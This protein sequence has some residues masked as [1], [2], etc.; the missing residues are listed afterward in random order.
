MI[1]FFLTFVFSLNAQE[2]NLDLGQMKKQ[3]K[4]ATV[5]IDDPV[6]GEKKVFDAFLLKDVVSLI[7]KGTSATESSGADDELMFTAID[8]YSPTMP[9]SALETYTGYVA[10]QE[11]GTPGEFHKVTQGKAKLSPGPFY[12]VWKEGRAVK[13]VVPWA[14][15]VVKMSIVPWSKKF[16][17]V[18]PAGIKEGSQVHKGLLVFKSSCLK[19]HSMNGQGGEIG[20][21][22]NIPKNITEYWDAK[23]LKAF[24]HNPGDFRQKSKMPMTHLSPDD[25][26][27][28]LAYLKEMK[29]H[30]KL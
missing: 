24:I 6:F 20:P 22:L 14:Y 15:Q 19:C 17:A 11:H 28:V 2:L 3:L 13:D 30:K 26:D 16:A 23:I 12:V 9:L 5:K 10:Y 27:A 8:G 7:P 29:N 25:L 18:I 21:E 4:T 1:S